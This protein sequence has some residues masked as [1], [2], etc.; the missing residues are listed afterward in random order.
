LVADN[1]TG[2][3]F[4]DYGLFPYIGLKEPYIRIEAKTYSTGYFSES[5]PFIEEIKKDG[6][7]IIDR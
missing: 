2:Y 7:I 6:I 3:G 5:D 1:F 4:I